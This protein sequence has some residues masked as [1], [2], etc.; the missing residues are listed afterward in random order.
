MAISDRILISPS[1]YLNNISLF[2]LEDDFGDVYEAYEELYKQ[3]NTPGRGVREEEAAEEFYEEVV[4]Y[5][6]ADQEIQNK[7]GE[8]ALLFKSMNP[9][10]NPLEEKLTEEE[11]RKALGDN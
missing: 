5:L 2:S 3:A 6:N 7:G 10:I 11:L 9:G 8:L 4:G 1:R